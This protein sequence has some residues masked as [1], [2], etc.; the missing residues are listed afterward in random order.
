MAE[1]RRGA[2]LSALNAI[3]QFNAGVVDNTLGLLDLGAQG[4]AG[5]S[6]MITGRND[7]PVMLGQRAKSALN[8]ESDP[9]SPSY[10]AGSVAP[11]VATGATAMA[12][13]GVSSIRNFF[14]GTTAE[15]GGYFGGEAGAQ[16]GREYG[17][18]YGELAGG[19][20]GGMVVPN[21]PKYDIFAGPSSRTADQE[22]LFRANQMERQGASPEEIKRATGFQK[23]LDGE[24]MYHIPDNKSALNYELMKTDMQDLMESDR[25]LSESMRTEYGIPKIRSDFQR[26]L[27]EVL[28]HPELYNAYP[29]LYT[30]PVSYGVQPD[31]NSRGTY[32]PRSKQITL[33]FDHLN[34]EMAETPISRDA[35][36]TLLHEINHA[37]SDIEGRSTGGSPSSASEQMLAAQRV[38]QEP[39]DIDYNN[40]KMS[41]KG[42]R[43]INRDLAILDLEDIGKRGSI[44]ELVGHHLFKKREGRIISELGDPFAS[45]DMSEWARMAAEKAKSLELEQLDPLTYN[46]HFN[47]K[48]SLDRD[49]LLDAREYLSDQKQA[50]LE[51]YNKYEDI[52]R[53]YS[54]LNKRAPNAMDKYLLIN[55]EF[56]SR[57]VQNLMDD[58][59]STYDIPLYRDVPDPRMGKLSTDDLFNSPNP[60]VSRET[61]DINDLDEDQYIQAINP[62]GIRIAPEARPNLGMGDMYGMA[63]RNAEEIMTQELRSGD[64]IRYVRDGDSVY[65]LGYNPDLGEEDVVGYMLGG[66]DGSELAVVDQMQGQGIGGNLSYLYRSQNPMAPSGGFT[67]AGEAAARKAY[68]RMMGYE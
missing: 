19:L 64:T 66:G 23:N 38:E 57:T 63:P 17:G 46:A 28:D 59:R 48:R 35:K 10:I 50:S 7:R 29:D 32:D 21:A 41:D 61:L 27:G 45:E 24:Y 15:L 3:A 16:L 25:K 36:S 58:P 51:G 49:G 14:G 56:L 39:F 68:R 31:R 53:K 54:E 60:Y 6:N 9:N 47:R 65:A 40:Y 43:D 20:V 5:I 26:T 37:V 13:R 55:D 42:I 34:D 67:E 11:A 62:Q 30:M 4:I 52:N 33:N 22:A 2:G 8:V 1:R 44:D 18:D 12:R